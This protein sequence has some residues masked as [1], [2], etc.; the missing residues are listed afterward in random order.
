[1]P[2]FV[3]RTKETTMKRDLFLV[4]VGIM[5]LGFASWATSGN[6]PP[7]THFDAQ[8]HSPNEIRIKFITESSPYM[9]TER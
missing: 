9:R 1:M 8:R 3:R 5:V 7:E 4:I 6:P 2:M